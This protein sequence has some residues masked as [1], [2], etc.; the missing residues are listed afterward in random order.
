MALMKLIDTNGL[1]GIIVTSQKI[2]EKILPQLSRPDF[3]RT[4]ELLHLDRLYNSDI[5][6]AHK[7]LIKL[8]L[9]SV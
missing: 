3:L 5:F 9:R 4:Y 7:K 6:Q 8:V 1:A 2:R